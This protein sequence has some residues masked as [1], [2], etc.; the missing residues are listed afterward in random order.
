MHNREGQQ[1]PSS[2]L[3]IKLKRSKK[4]QGEYD[5]RISVDMSFEQATKLRELIPWGLRRALFAQ[6]MTSVIDGLEGD[7][8]DFISG[9]IV[10]GFDLKV[11]EN[12]GG[13]KKPEEK[14]DGDD[15]R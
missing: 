7:R 12:S 10:N 6:L 5:T 13:P 1:C 2:F 4:M 3:L 14:R 15:R 8:A 11:K 9:G